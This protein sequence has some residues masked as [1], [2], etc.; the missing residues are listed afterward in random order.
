MSTFFVRWRMNPKETFKTA[1]E[2]GEFVARMLDE[3]KADLQ[4]GVM[5]DWGCY[6]DGSG[7]YCIY[8][9]QSEANVFVSIHKWTPQINFDVRQVLTVEQLLEARKAVPPSDRQIP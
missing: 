8:E 9:A 6:I 7:G 1:E 3:A 4:A 2:R 5:K